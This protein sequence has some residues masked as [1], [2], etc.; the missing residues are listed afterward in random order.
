VY[1]PIAPL[2]VRKASGS[3]GGGQPFTG[4]SR[5]MN[6]LQDNLITVSDAQMSTTCVLCQ[7][8][9][10]DSQWFCRLPQKNGAPDSE[11]NRILLCSPS[12]AYRYFAFLEIGASRI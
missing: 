7:K 12:C 9:I 11:T 1:F 8:P 10:V 4:A 3:A 6:N 2:G 5:P